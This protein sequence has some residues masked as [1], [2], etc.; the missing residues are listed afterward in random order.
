MQKLN[1]NKALYELARRNLIDL[2]TVLVP[3]FEITNFHYNYY[4]ILQLFSEGKIK[5]LI[6]TVPPQHG[7]TEGATKILPCKLFGLNPNLKIVI[8]SYSAT[9]ARSFNRQIQ[10][11]IDTVEY[12]SIYPKTKINSKRVVNTENWLRNADEFEIINSTGILKSVGRGGGLTGH[13]VDI[14]IL[15]DIYKDFAEANSPV[16]RESAWDWYVNV[17]KTRLHNESQ[18]LIVFTRWHEDDL[19]GRL[20]KIEQ[21]I[22]IKSLSE[23]ENIPLNSWIKINFQAIKEN[24]T[25]DLDSRIKGEALWDNKHNLNSLYEAKALDINR[26][27]CLY[28][29]NPQSKEGQLYD[30]FKTYSKIENVTK[31]GNYTDT[32]DEGTDYLCSICYD[33][34]GE[35]IYVTDILY[36][37]EPM[38]ITEPATANLLIRNNTRTATIESNNGGRGFARQVEKLAK[39]CSI[40]WFH[41]S[42]NKESR[43]LTNSATVNK[44]IYM[45]EDWKIRFKEFYQHISMFKRIYSANK[46]KDCADVLTGIVEKEKLTRNISRIL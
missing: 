23:I 16:I 27:E 30:E 42:L 9:L 35:N 13:P 22:E 29:G 40:T 34:S 33:I 46:Y 18:Q 2:A 8:A 41:Q 3:E 39:N 44:F 37:Q 45:P 20:S 36:T 32:A 26:F 28:Q 43:I 11:Y 10:R 19:I 24:E 17:V 15:D 21:I 6:V 31:K 38:E 25:T 7:K 1:C 4:K 5:K 12:E 14:M